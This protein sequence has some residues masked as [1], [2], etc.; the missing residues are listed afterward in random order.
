MAGGEVAA[1]WPPAVSEFSSGPRTDY[2]PPQVWIC[3]ATWNHI[4][5]KSLCWC[6][7]FLALNLPVRLCLSQ[8]LFFLW[9]TNRLKTN[10]LDLVKKDVLFSRLGLR[11]LRRT[12]TRFQRPATRSRRQWSRPIR[13]RKLKSDHTLNP[14]PISNLLQYIN[15]NP[16]KL[17]ISWLNSMII[18]IAM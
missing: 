17:H 9:S 13:P 11:P 14:N 3:V 5:L 2:L 15:G 6:K 1:S 16:N 10:D 12:S 8:S 18:F 4:F 7:S